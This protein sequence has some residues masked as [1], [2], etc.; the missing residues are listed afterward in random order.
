MDQAYQARQVL[1]YEI[2]RNSCS[3]CSTR[4][5]RPTV[6]EPLRFR[7]WS[8]AS[9]AVSVAEAETR[10]GALRV[11]PKGLL[12]RTTHAASNKIVHPPPLRHTRSLSKH[13]RLAATG[14]STPKSDW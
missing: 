1:L 5:A 8:A 4:D 14:R 6:R 7:R 3:G 9:W 2:V 12:R 10:A 13:E 11:A